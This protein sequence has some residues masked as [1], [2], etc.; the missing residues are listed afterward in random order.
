MC[1]LLVYGLWVAKM[2]VPSLSKYIFIIIFLVVTYS[3]AFDVSLN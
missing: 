3:D 2:Y 1:F